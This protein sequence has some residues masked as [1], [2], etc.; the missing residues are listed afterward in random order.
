M[1]PENPFAFSPASASCAKAP[2]RVNRAH[3]LRWRLALVGF[4]QTLPTLRPLP[5]RSMVK[6][7]RA[8][9][10]RVYRK[11]VPFLTLRFALLTGVS[12]SPFGSIAKVAGL[13]VAAPMNDG[14]V[15]SGE[16]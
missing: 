9:S 11:V 3:A 6:T 16:P 1:R 12:A 5:L 7:T 14:A 8:G 2:T 4:R 10:V 15:V 13:A